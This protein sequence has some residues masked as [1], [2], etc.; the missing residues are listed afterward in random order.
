[1]LS[2]KKAAFDSE[3]VFDEMPTTLLLS[4][5]P[6]PRQTSL[7]WKDFRFVINFCERACFP[8]IMD[9]LF[10]LLCLVCSIA[11]PKLKFGDKILA[12][13]YLTL[14]DL[15]S[16]PDWSLYT[17]RKC[18]ARGSDPPC[19]TSFFCFSMW[20]TTRSKLKMSSLTLYGCVFCK[21]LAY[22]LFEATI[23]ST[24]EL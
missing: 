6:F 20:W 13:D 5:L 12:C 24:K 3:E 15:I 7:T 23:L 22:L 10:L 8:K 21:D 9:L 16:Y 19:E 18:P 17:I 2:C 1:M 14:Y 4:E 11:R